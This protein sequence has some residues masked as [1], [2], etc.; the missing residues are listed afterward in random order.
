[1]APRQESG[2]STFCFCFHLTEFEFEFA[3]FG[4]LGK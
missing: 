1:M 2:K 3:L 4:L